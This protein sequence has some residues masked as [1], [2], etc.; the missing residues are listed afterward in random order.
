MNSEVIIRELK[1]E[2]KDD[3]SG[4]V[5]EYIQEYVQIEKTYPI[6]YDSRIGP[7][8]WDE[9]KKRPEDYV[10]LVAE[11]DGKLC[12]LCIGEIKHFGEIEKVYFEGVQR[13]EVWDI[14]VNPANRGKGIGEQMINRIESLFLEKGCPNVVLNGVNIRNSGAIKLYEKLGYKTW[15]MKY[16][17]KV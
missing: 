10:V 4:L 3:F 7:T 14:Y 5:N 9:I 13:G 17:K 11:V 6:K 15:N 2:D 1:P 8:Y 12:G 16:Y